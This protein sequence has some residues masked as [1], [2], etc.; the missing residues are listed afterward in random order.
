VI[1]LAA[2]LAAASGSAND[3]TPGAL[4]FVVVAAMGVALFFLLRSMTKHLR[5]VRAARDAGLEPGQDPAQ[6]GTDPAQ[7][8]TDPAQFGATPESSSREP[9]GSAGG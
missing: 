2:V 4:G 7:V 1:S 3:V 5:R 8:G 9:N 6:F